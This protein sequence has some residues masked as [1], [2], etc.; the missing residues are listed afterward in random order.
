[1]TDFRFTYALPEEEA[2]KGYVTMFCSRCRQLK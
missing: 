1:M 2:V